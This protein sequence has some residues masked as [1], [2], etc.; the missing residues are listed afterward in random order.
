[1]VYGTFIGIQETNVPCDVDYLSDPH[2]KQLEVALQ[3]YTSDLSDSGL[4][5][6]VTLDRIKARIESHIKKKLEDGLSKD[7]LTKQL[8]DLTMNALIPMDINDWCYDRLDELCKEHDEKM[9]NSRDSSSHSSDDFCEDM[10]PIFSTDA[11]Y[12]ASLCNLVI[13]KARSSH[14]GM[15]TSL[16]YLSQFGHSFDKATLSNDMNI[17]IA[18]QENIIYIAFK[19]YL[20]YLFSIFKI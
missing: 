19:G 3:V 10:P 1:M 18:L 2:I 11:V 4:D 8:N 12:H 7:T 20:F 15:K 17:L 16:D 9:S 13:S 6:Q 14:L 5:T